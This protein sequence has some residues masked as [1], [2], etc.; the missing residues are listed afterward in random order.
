MDEVI[1]NLWIS[2]MACALSA[3]H[4]IQANIT[5][6]ITATSSR[7]A[8]PA[9]PADH[10]QI[11]QLHIRIDDEDLAPIIVHF[12][13]S[14]QFI[15]NAIGKHQRERTGNENEIGKKNNV[16]VHCHAGVSRSVTVSKRIKF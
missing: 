7:L 12:E 2:D 5:H 10:P 8:L 3:E 1:S 11:S 4:L 13:K 6:I 14:N 9:L 15:E 16:L